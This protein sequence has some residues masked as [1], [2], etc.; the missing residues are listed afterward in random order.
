[1]KRISHYQGTYEPLSEDHDKNLSFIKIFD[2]G[3]KFLVNKV[4]GHIQS[5]I[6]YYLMN[7]QVVPRTIY[8]TR[9]G[10]SEYN[11][12]G[13]IGG[14]ANLSLQGE[15]YARKL[16]H[17]ID[18]ECIND[19]TVWTSELKRTKQTAEFIHANQIN[20]KALNEINAGICEEMT[21]EEIQEQ[22][23]KEFA[24]RDE[25]KY[26]YRYPKGESYADLVARLEPVIMELEKQENILVIAHQA[27]A[28]C[29]LA[30]F[31]DKPSE[32][33]PYLKVPLHTVL[34]L[35]PYA[36]GCKVEPIKLDVPAVDTYRE[37]PKVVGE[38]RSAEDALATV[39]PHL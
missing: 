10:E 4:L 11:L 8:L 9:H 19:L 38:A 32:E 17:Y 34:K 6:V 1:M 24:S 12:L 39:P 21:Y 18:E 7:I 13:R 16:A 36:Y 23:P 2:Q 37:K 31:L 5:R 22:H 27:V 14:D 33:L 28:R 15:Q 25:D 26:T 20:W 30:Y 29:L 35:T 3:D